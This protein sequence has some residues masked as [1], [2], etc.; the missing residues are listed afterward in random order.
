MITRNKDP[1]ARAREQSADKI[2]NQSLSGD[3]EIR[4]PDSR[5]RAVIR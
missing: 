2:R 3:A 5:R 1:A 4:A